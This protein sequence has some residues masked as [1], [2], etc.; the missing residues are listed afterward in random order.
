MD[1]E[2]GRIIA[3][4][5]YPV[6]SMAG[7]LIDS[8]QLGS[9]GLDGDRRF[10]FRRLAEGNGFPWLIASRLP[11]LILYQPH[12]RDTSAQEPLPTHVRTPEGA[13]FDL[14]GAELRDDVS[15][16]FGS[17]VELMQLKHGIF[18]EASLSVIDV[19]TI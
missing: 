13:E 7:Q 11:E 1:I 19:A 6:K 15:R 16:R 4:F 2:L 14:R 8:A 9:H 12:G 17:D 5:R 18:D 3:I 10:G